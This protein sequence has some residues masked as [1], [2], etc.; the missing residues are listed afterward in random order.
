MPVNTDIHGKPRYF[1]GAPAWYQRAAREAL[2]ADTFP[3]LDAMPQ[4]GHAVTVAYGGETG[5]VAV[6][7]M[8]DTRKKLH[9]ERPKSA[10]PGE[11]WT[12][13]VNTI[14]VTLSG[15]GFTNVRRTNLGVWADAPLP[16]GPEVELHLTPDPDL[17]NVGVYHLTIPNYPKLRARIDGGFHHGV[18]S[19]SSGYTAFDSTGKT[20][21]NTGFRSADG[22]L[23]AA[24][25]YGGY[26]G[27]PTH[28]IKVLDTET[29]ALRIVDAAFAQGGPG[30]KTLVVSVMVRGAEVCDRA[31][32]L[33]L[34]GGIAAE[35]ADG[36]TRAAQKRLARLV[37][38][39]LTHDQGR[40]ALVTP[41][42]DGSTT[43]RWALNRQGAMQMP[44]SRIAE[45]APG[46]AVA[47]AP[48]L[49]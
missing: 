19:G 15:A 44:L 29:R 49:A 32:S 2:P 18:T 39:A 47:P 23:R 3:D 11:R 10:G 1:E 13:L 9:T 33:R 28:L 12:A 26:C 5:R 27:I 25:A 14:A 6:L 24:R 22:Y 38:H 46:T 43:Q 30:R 20:V 17:L 21:P 40:M 31:S 41:G 8:M 37:A 36:Y 16:A 34:A 42:P 48:H 4:G 35:P 7:L 45:I